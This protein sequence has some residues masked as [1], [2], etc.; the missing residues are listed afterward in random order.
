MIY[1]L[2]MVLELSN[3]ICLTVDTHPLLMPW[4]WS[5]ESTHDSRGDFFVGSCLADAKYS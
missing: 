5:T 1:E 3:Y 2:L 4:Q